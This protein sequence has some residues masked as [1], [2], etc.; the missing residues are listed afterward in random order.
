[1]ESG[2]DEDCSNEELN[3][4]A[5]LFYF[6]VGLEHSLDI[7]VAL[8]SQQ[9]AILASEEARRLERRVE[10]LGFGAAGHVSGLAHTTDAL[11]TVQ[12]DSI[13]ATY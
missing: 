1:M 12:I 4:V 11:G 7:G 8:A 9:A 5:A 3:V 13:T 2:C 10:G 6:G